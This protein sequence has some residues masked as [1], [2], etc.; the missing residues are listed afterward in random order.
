MN[1]YDQSA[2]FT[3]AEKLALTARLTRA[4]GTARRPVFKHATR[5]AAVL[6]AAAMLMVAAAGAA[7][8]GYIWQ[9]RSLTIEGQR[10]NADALM[11]LHGDG[12][13]TVIV[14]GA[15]GEHTSIEVPPATV[16]GWLDGTAGDFTASYDSEEPYLL[17]PQNGRLVLRIQN[18]V[19]LDVT[20]L[21]GE[22]YTFTYADGD[23]TQKTATVK[24]TVENYAVE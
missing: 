20:D 4:A 8:V 6:C 12:S 17:E 16:P 10:V 11:T 13:A 1:G 18:R 15:N 23:G 19:P 3:E 22:G 9:G 5:R 7:T 21:L 24:G 14:T 2:G